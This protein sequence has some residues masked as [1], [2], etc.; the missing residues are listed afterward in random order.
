V[1][2]NCDDVGRFQKRKYDPFPLWPTKRKYDPFL[3]S[4]VRSIK[5]EKKEKANKMV[6]NEGK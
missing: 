3:S 1:K 4:P 6:V 2:M 5:S